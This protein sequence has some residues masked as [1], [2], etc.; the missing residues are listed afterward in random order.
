MLKIAD[1][2]TLITKMSKSEKRNFKLLA[3]KTGSKDK[4][5]VQLFDFIEK[6]KNYDVALILKSIPSIKKSQLSNVKAMLSKQILRSLI[7]VH[8]E[9]YIELKAREKFNFA[10]VLYT[11]GL[12]R[13]SLD[14]LDVVIKMAEEYHMKPLGFMAINFEKLIES[15]H[16][17]KSMSPRAYKLAT[18]SDNIVNQLSV[19]NELSNLA[20]LLYARYL[21]NGYVKNEEEYKQLHQY[22][23][24]LLPI[25]DINDLGFYE[26]LNLYQSFVWFYYMAQNF[27]SYYKYS[28]KW[29][30]L[31]EEY[32]M[33]MRPATIHY[34]K[35][36]NNVLTALFMAQKQEM[37]NDVYIKLNEIS[38]D[39]SK[40]LSVNEKAQL[41]L[42][43]Y[44]HGLNHIFIGANYQSGYSFIENL[45][46]TI[47]KQTYPWDVSRI[48]V[49]N[50]KIACFYFGIGDLSTTISYLNKVENSFQPRLKV[51]IQCFA[52]VLNLIAHYDLG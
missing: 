12:Y 47:A 17:T 48:M 50:Y 6:S 44:I 20:L 16:V 40:N 46:M 7:D 18:T 24:S 15:Q 34:I 1:V 43:K 28:I 8:K 23:H 9:E 5:Y 41:S 32:P 36:L 51:D 14:M 11:M 33:M 39:K 49:F 21:E 29:I 52:R 2:V 13:A 38:I 3:Q 10:K 27:V 30:L 42:F 37:F 45:E 31:F 19:A 4:L 22:F 25:Y 26:K 35:G